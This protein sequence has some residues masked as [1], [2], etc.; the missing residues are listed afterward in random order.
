MDIKD[1]TCA[2]IARELGIDPAGLTG[3]QYF[4]S[5]PNVDSMRVLQIIVKTEKAF[6]IEIDDDV[7][8]KIQTIGEFQSLVAKLVQ[9]RAAA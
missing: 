9:Q 3:D 4:R 1:E 7:T 6:D 8:F 2:I 5:L